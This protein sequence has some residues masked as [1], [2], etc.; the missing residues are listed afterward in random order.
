MSFIQDQQSRLT[1]IC[2][3]VIL[4]KLGEKPDNI[5]ILVGERAIERLEK[6]AKRHA[7]KNLYEKVKRQV[8][9]EIQVLVADMIKDIIRFGM[10]RD[11]NF[12]M[13]STYQHADEDLVK[14]AWA[15]AKSAT[16]SF[17]NE[18]FSILIDRYVL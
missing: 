6:T 5:Q 8:A 3:D 14:R 15:I 4:D 11:S 16:E 10:G 12:F 2:S 7:K 9:D 17:D 18:R 13:V 1:E